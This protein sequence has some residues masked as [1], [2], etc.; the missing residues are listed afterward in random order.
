MWEGS[1]PSL[2]TYMFRIEMA[3]SAQA[4]S[5]DVSFFVDMEA[6]LTVIESED[7]TLNSDLAVMGLS[8]GYVALYI[9]T[10]WAC[11]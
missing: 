11:H 3:S 4:S 8:E 1:L 6:I 5:R 2:P 10:L 7:G 9:R